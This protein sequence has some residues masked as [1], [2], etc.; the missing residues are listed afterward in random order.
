MHPDPI[1]R[2][3]ADMADKLRHWMIEEL[4]KLGSVRPEDFTLDPEKLETL[5]FQEL[6]D[7]LYD[8]IEPVPIDKTRPS[9]YLLKFLMVGAKESGK[10]IF[11]GKIPSL[12]Q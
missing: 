7:V 3:E 8:L 12:C 6:T 9:E 4:P 11:F 1:K 5:N 2:L 10:S